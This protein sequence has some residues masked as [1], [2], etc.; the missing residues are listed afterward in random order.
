MR[1]A[2]SQQLIRQ[3]RAPSYRKQVEVICTDKPSLIQKTREKIIAR[4]LGVDQIFCRVVQPRILAMEI[5]GSRF[6]DL[7]SSKRL[8]LETEHHR[9]N[10][11]RCIDWYRIAAKHV[12]CLWNHRDERLERALKRR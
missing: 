8:A 5:P 1:A 10:N 2:S 9:N 4:Q 11:P 6:Y 3:T 7:P 12:G